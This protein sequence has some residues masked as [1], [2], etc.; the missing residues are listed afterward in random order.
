MDIAA[1]AQM[2]WS[3]DVEVMIPIAMNIS[4]KQA[5]SFFKRETRY[6]MFN[7]SLE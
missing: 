4:C 6:V 1:P 3:V 2:F 5:Q 7:P